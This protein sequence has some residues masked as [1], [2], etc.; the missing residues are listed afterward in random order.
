LVQS[1]STKRIMIGVIALYA[2]LLQSFAVSA[3]PAAGFDSFGGIAC[4]QGAG[5][6]AAPANDLHRR[7]G[8]CCLLVCAASG[9][10]GIAITSLEV[11]FAGLFASPYVFGKT[12]GG[13]VRSPLRF[14][15]AAR[16]P[17]QGT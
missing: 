6:P 9:F 17:P 7:H 2:V 10:I 1:V 3:F 14:Y 4:L 11:V 8:V 13:I 12:Q 16:G 15:F 5:T